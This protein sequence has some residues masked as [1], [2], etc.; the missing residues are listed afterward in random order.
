MFEAFDFIKF[1]FIDFV[2]ILVVGLLLYYVYRLLKGTVA[3]NIFLGIVIIFVIWRVTQILGMELLSGILGQF[4]GIGL[5]ALFV[6]FQQE[7]RKFL[8]AIGST[9]FFKKGIIKRFS[10]FL[11]NSSDNIDGQRTANELI[12][13]C[14]KMS[15]EKTGALIILERNQSLDFVR[16]SGDKMNI[17]LNAPILESIFY[18]NSPLHDGA[19]VVKNNYIVATRVILPVVG[20]NSIPKHFGLRHRAAVSITEKTDATAIVVSEETGKIS[21]IKNGD[22]VLYASQEEL[23]EIITQDLV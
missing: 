15:K 4:I 1:T 13:A 16:T 20:Q 6:V 14:W 5:I 21:Y 3:I 17:E 11:K 7:I 22:F 12:F 23:T 2:D 8:L 10:A 18:K 9:N 19:I